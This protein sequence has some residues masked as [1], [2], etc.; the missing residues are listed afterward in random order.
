MV[1]K[2]AVLS[3]PLMLGSKV[4]NTPGKTHILNCRWKNYAATDYKISIVIVRVLSVDELY[5]EVM[6]RAPLAAELTRK[7]ILRMFG[8][9]DDLKMDN[10]RESLTCPVSFCFN[11]C[12]RIMLL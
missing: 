4:K 11:G 9:E 10:F 8:E 7:K 3:E 1:I 6:K 2:K 12:L 5:N